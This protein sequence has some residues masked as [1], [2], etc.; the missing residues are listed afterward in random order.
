MGNTISDNVKTNTTGNITS[1]LQNNFSDDGGIVNLINDIFVKMGVLMGKN[2]DMLREYN[3]VQAVNSFNMQRTAYHTRINSIND[4]LSANKDEADGMLIGGSF[5]MAGSV[6]VAKIPGM[7]SAGNGINAV[8]Q[9][10]EKEKANNS[11]SLSKEEQ[12]LSDF[13]HGTGEQLLKR[14]DETLNKALKVSEDLRQLLSSLTQVHD[15]IASVVK[16]F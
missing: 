16:S 13:Q 11:S 1:P 12:A 4:E 10:G 15:R 9:G 5:M 8:A 7:D 14:S 3:Q 2:R 6:A